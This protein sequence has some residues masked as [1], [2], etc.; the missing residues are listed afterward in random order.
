[1]QFTRITFCVEFW[2][3]FYA[4][5]EVIVQLHVIYHSDLIKKLCNPIDWLILQL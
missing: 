3:E 1:M 4:I 2:I 5:V